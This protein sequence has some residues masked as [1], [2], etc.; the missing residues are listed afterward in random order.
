MLIYLLFYGKRR[1]K[2]PTTR[3]DR[4]KKLNAID[5]PNSLPEATSLKSFLLLRI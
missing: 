4:D 2:Y 1:R 3:G 5:L